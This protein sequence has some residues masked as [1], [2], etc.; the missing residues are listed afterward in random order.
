MLSSKTRQY[1]Y[2][3]LKDWI[4]LSKDYY[5]KSQ[6][7]SPNELDWVFEKVVGGKI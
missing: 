5:N 6:K 3:D 2:L 1:I 7:E 4:T